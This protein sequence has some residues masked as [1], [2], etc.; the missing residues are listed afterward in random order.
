MREK[1]LLKRKVAESEEN[2]DSALEKALQC[3]SH[4]EMSRKLRTE[5]TKAIRTLVSQDLPDLCRTV[6]YRCKTVNRLVRA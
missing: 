6:A 4:F 3:L 1:N 5:Q 2:F